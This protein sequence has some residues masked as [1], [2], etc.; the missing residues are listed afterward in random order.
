MSFERFEDWLKR[1]KAAWE[2]RDP[3]AA[4]TIFTPKATYQVTPFREPEMHREGIRAYWVRATT[5]QRNVQFGSEML[6]SNDDTGV[7]RWNCHFDLASEGVH[8]EIDGIFVFSL[9][10]DGLCHTFQEWWHD[11]VTEQAS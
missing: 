1:Y 5:D 2:T 3:D 6:A 8:V 10:E 9:T 11:Q 7:C 4:Q